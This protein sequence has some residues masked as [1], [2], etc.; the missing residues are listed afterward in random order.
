MTN[1]RGRH[2]K[3]SGHNRRWKSRLRTV[4]AGI[5]GIIPVLAVFTDELL[6]VR[7]VPILVSL[8]A[9]LAATNNVLTSTPWRTFSGEFMPWLYDYEGKHRKD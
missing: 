2:A 4:T 5:I 7:D 6:A 8:A 9:V 1:G 3:P